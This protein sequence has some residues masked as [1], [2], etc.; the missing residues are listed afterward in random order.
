MLFYIYFACVA[1]CFIAAF[2]YGSN[3]IS[4]K[5]AL[6]LRTAMFFTVSADFCM[7]ILKDNF[8]GV[9]IF[10][11]AHILYNLRYGAKPKTV[12]VVFM[13]LLAVCF[14]LSAVLPLLYAISLIYGGLFLSGA[15][16]AVMA[17]RRGVYPR[18]NGVFILFGILLF[19]ICDV[20]VALL[21][22]T[23]IRIMVIISGFFYIPSQ[24][25][26]ALSAK[27][28]APRKPEPQ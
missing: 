24:L 28:F 10:C 22:I 2:S 3:Y 14:C 16:H 5:D 7:L 19:V 4:H 15:F 20:F 6:L 17:F 9:I 26:L 1:A 11:I 13:A 12:A 23:Q 25:L 21:N 8:R 18:R 27:N